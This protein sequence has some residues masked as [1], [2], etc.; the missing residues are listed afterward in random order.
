MDYDHPETGT[1]SSRVTMRNSDGSFLSH[2]SEFTGPY[3]D[4]SNYR[5]D[6]TPPFVDGWHD[7]NVQIQLSDSSGQ[8]GSWRTSSTLPHADV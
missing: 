7:H 5:T 4:N 6:Y 3:W 2:K 1:E 8:A